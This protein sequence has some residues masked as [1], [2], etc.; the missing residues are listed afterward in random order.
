MLP[1]MRVVAGAAVDGHA[2]ERRQIAGGAEAVVAAVH[3]EH[4][5]F[6]GPDVDAEG[7]GIDAVEPHAR[8]VGGSGEDLRAVAA[9]DLDGIGAVAALDQIGIVAGVPDHAVVAGLAEHLVVAVP[10][11]QRVVAVAAVQK[12]G[13]LAADEGVVAR[14]AIEGKLRDPGRHCRGR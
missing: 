14:A 2:D 10:A 1:R 7:R 8:A 4:K 5:L 13:A 6:G 11:G 12:V 3:V 9:V